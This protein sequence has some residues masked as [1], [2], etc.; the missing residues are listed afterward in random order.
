MA[1]GTCR[2]DVRYRVRGLRDCLNVDDFRTLARRRLPAPIFH[3]VD[4]AAESEHTYRRSLLAWDEIGMAHNALV[5]VAAVDTATTVLGQRIAM[6]LLL[7]PTG[8]ARLYHWRGELAVARACA[9]AGTFYG[10]SMGSTFSLEEIAAAAD[11]PKLFQLYVFRDRGLSIELIERC[12]GAGYAAVCLT[13]DT[14]VPGMRERDLRTGMTVPPAFGW[15]TLLDFAAHPAW[16]LGLLRGGRLRM[17]NLENRAEGRQDIT[18]LARFLGG[19]LDP[20]VTWEDARRL[21]EAWG[22]PFAVKGIL[23]VADARRAVEI[24][25]SAIIVSNHGGRQFDAGITPIE[26]LPRIADAVG[27]QIEIIL[28][29]GIRRGMH[30][31]KALAL[32]ATA[33][34]MGRPHVFG[35]AAG[36]EAGVRQLLALL[37][38]EIRRNMILMG[39]ATIDAVSR[40]MITN[41]RIAGYP[42]HKGDLGMAA[43]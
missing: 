41:D 7:S 17:G 16:T 20:S 34:A 5:D 30:V 27:G 39:C 32:G 37:H 36:G 10:V 3:Y 28:D 9:A 14:P 21:V 38:A 6:P 33:C 13:V 12:K 11:G 26:M 15:K 2:T 29:G 22:G 4:G 24:G 19:Q 1:A 35:L 40:S 42:I 8:T 25:A 23:S 18:T 43:V 31:L